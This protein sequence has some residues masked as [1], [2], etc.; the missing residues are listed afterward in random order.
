[1]SLMVT[2]ALRLPAA[3]GVK[4]TEMVQVPLAARLLE[5]VLVWAKSA[6][7]V[8]LIAILLMLRVAWPLLASVTVWALL[9][10]FTTWLA[11]LKLLGFKLAAG[12][13]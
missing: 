4:V 2:L 7:F 5:Q 3:L 8:P 12:E 9:V 10:V 1:M 13:G 6:A 11:K